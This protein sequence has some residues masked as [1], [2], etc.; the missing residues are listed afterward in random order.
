MGYYINPKNETKEAFLSR[1]RKARP[2]E[3]YV[4]WTAAEKPDLVPPSFAEFARENLPVCWVNNGRFTAAAIGYD[5]EE[6][7][8]FLLGTDDRPYQWYF[9][10]QEDL[11]EFLVSPVSA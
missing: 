1:Y 2:S 10:P 3:V 4:F 7:E 5:R 11:A 6:T 8:R 9:V